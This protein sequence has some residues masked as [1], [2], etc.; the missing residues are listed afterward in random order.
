LNADQLRRS[1]LRVKA[2][3][4]QDFAKLLDHYRQ[5]E[6]AF[7]LKQPMQGPAEVLAGWLAKLT[8]DQ[9]ELLVTMATL[10]FQAVQIEATD[11]ML[12]GK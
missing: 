7:V 5:R 11:Q 3:Y 1:T 10:M 6:L 12:R 4:D 9:Q 8:P 2:T